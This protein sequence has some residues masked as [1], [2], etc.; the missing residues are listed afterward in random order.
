M[1]CKTGN[2][3]GLP[4]DFFIECVH[5]CVCVCVCV[6]EC[7]SLCDY[8]CTVIV[9]IRPCG[10]LVYELLPADLDRDILVCISLNVQFRKM[11]FV[12]PIVT[13][14]MKPCASF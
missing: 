13:I 1:S 3:A 12:K 5:V 9:N 14:P 6:C 8:T 11:S 10:W 7:V 2:A 4:S